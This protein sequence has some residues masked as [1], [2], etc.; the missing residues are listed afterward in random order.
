MSSTSKS[1]LQII[2]TSLDSL[3]ATAH[4]DDRNELVKELRDYLSRQ[5]SAAR[6]PGYDKH[7]NPATIAH[8]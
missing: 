3:F 6:R 4:I 8:A 1:R 5:S 2:M 7:T